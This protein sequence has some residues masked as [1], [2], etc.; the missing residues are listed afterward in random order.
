MTEQA[1]PARHRRIDAAEVNGVDVIDDGLRLRLR[2]RDQDGRAASVSLPADSL[3][4][5]L[6]AAL[7]DAGE[8]P[9]GQGAVQRL[10]GWSLRRGEHA[11][12]LTLSLPGGA[13]ITL[14][15]Q[16]WQ[17]AAIAS[18]AGQ[19]LAGQDSGPPRRRLN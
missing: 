1:P 3:G 8:P 19:G 14:A 2:L 7:R 13:T 17:I 15:V 12:L 18:L 16:P 4:A 9:A 6:A 11:L 5:V 10:E